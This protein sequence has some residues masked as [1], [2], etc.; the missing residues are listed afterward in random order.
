MN[1]NVINESSKGL[2]HEL[3]TAISDFKD[4]DAIND[5]AEAWNLKVVG[6][7]FNYTVDEKLESQEIII[8][9]SF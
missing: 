1:I 5:I 9:D 7:K 4:F 3:L 6:V 8:G 2:P